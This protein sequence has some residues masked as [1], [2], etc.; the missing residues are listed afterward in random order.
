[1]SK[2]VLI[3]IGSVLVVALVGVA[4]FFGLN[5]N[6]SST[7]EPKPTPTVE[8][9]KPEAPNPDNAKK[10]EDESRSG[11]LEIAIKMFPNTEALGEYSKEDISLALY[12]YTT[13]NNQ[14]LNDPYLMFGQWGEENFPREYIDNKYKMYFSPEGYLPISVALDEYKKGDDLDS[15]AGKILAK[16]FNFIDLDPETKPLD[17]CL[18]GTNENCFPEKI[19]YGNLDY[20]LSEDGKELIITQTVNVSMRFNIVSGGTGVIKRDYTITA[21]M[22]PNPESDKEY[23]TPGWLIVDTYNGL[24]NEGTLE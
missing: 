14:A 17:G 9:E 6:N 12:Y 15:E 21:V 16:V 4:V 23:Y 22:S 18:E 13:F 7:P 11:D 20:W 8:P 1:M 5:A 2:K 19:K 24:Y 10:V 3:I